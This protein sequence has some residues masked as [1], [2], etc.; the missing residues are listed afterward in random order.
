MSDYKRICESAGAEYIGTRDG[1]VVF[2][3]RETS[4]VLR[5]YAFSTTA[6]NV[7]LGL[8]SVREPVVGFEPLEATEKLL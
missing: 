1:I 3:C 5:L 2:R 6:E 4:N 7:R 8:K